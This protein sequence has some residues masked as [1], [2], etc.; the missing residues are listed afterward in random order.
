MEREI[1][2][3][4]EADIQHPEVIEPEEGDDGEPITIESMGLLGLGGGMDVVE[5]E[6]RI[7]GGSTR[8]L[9]YDAELDD[10]NDLLEHVRDHDLDRDD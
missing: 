1:P 7:Y 9:G 3:T 4:S 8:F 2:V 10:V 5:S 6:G